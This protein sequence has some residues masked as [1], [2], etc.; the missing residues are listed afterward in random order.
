M[1]NGSIAE[2]G[3]QTSPMRAKPNGV[4]PYLA[5]DQAMTSLYKAKP[6]RQQHNQADLL[7]DFHDSFGYRFPVKISME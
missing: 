6:S 2:T 4:M 5:A 1:T 7:S 3:T